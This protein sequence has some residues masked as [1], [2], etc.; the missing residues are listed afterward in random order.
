MRCSLAKRRRTSPR[1]HQRHPALAWPTRTASY[2]NTVLIAGVWAR[3]GR[4][5]DPEGNARTSIVRLAEHKTVP[6][7]AADPV[8]GAAEFELC[9]PRCRSRVGR[10][11]TSSWH[12][13]TGARRVRPWRWSYGRRRTRWIGSTD[14]TPTPFALANRR[15]A[16]VAVPPPAGESAVSEGISRDSDP[17]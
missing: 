11:L 3:V 17:L 4:D 8:F 2:D 10:A 6:A 13:E 1:P 12:A 14:P 9:E 7:S 5:L 15:Y 16:A